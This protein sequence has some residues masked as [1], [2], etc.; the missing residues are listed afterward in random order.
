[1]SRDAWLSKTA[2]FGDCFG[3][4]FGLSF[5][6]FRLC[7]FACQVCCSKECIFLH[8]SLCNADTMGCCTPKCAAITVPIVLILL[9]G[10]ATLIFFYF[11]RSAFLISKLTLNFSE[12]NERESAPLAVPTSDVKYEGL[13]DWS[14]QPSA[15]S[16]FRMNFTVRI[17]LPPQ[18]R[19]TTSLSYLIPHSPCR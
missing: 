4:T 13:N 6:R 5:F 15:P 12:S 8:L 14:V 3:F 10:L 11:P 7:Y 19:Q 18:E 1:V 17:T 9:G 16:F 2:V